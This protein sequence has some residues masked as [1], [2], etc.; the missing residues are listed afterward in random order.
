[1]TNISPKNSS[2]RNNEGVNRV[3]LAAVASITMIK[4]DRRIL[5]GFNWF[6]FLAILALSVAGVTA[7]WST[8]DGT[9]LNSYYGKQLTYLCC[10]LLV[11]ILLLYFDYHIFSDYITFIYLAG[12][13]VLG[14]VLIF[15]HRIHGNKSWLNLGAF[16]FQPSELIK[17]IVIIALAKYYS[18]LDREYLELREL[19]IGALIVFAPALLVVLQGDLGT[20][21]TFFPIY[22]VLSLL[23]GI[24][25]KHLVIVLVA[26]AVALPP[27]WSMLQNHQ[28]NRI[29]T[30]FNPSKDPQRLGYQTLQSEIAIGSGQFFGKGFKQGSQGR[31]GFVPAR[32][33][34]F[35]FAVFAEEK[36]FVGGI[37]ILGLFLFIAFEL[38][39]T[40]REAKDKIGALIVIGVLAMFL[41]HIF[42]NIG[43]VIGLIPIAGIPL[44]FV[45]AGGSSLISFY[46]AMSLCMSIRMRRYVN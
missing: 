27:A 28:R 37:A 29:E 16:S 34:D 46:A 26:V 44:P 41:F 33:T 35:V 31:G 20:A 12:L 9:S 8:T 40:A 19:A 5:L 38:F 32:H 43:M 11:F 17:I 36:G 42:I 25:R 24:R 23:A 13:L 21:V 2:I 14:A 10:S 4:V 7:I 1:M 22:A 30:V 39:R 18:E 45:S 3:R 15:G 6:L